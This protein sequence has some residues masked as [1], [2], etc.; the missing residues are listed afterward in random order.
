[1]R[2]AGSEDSVGGGMRHGV[3]SRGRRPRLMIKS[4]VASPSQGLN[5]A[6]GFVASN[7]RRWRVDACTARRWPVARVRGAA[8]HT[9]TYLRNRHVGAVH[10]APGHLSAAAHGLRRRRCHCRGRC[11]SVD[12]NRSTGGRGG[13]QQR[14]HHQLRRRAHG[15]CAAEPD[16]GWRWCVKKPKRQKGGLCSLLHFEAFPIIKMLA[17]QDT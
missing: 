17:I 1:M 3:D 12:N 16:V 2:L 11:A 5:W 10:H 15:V 7:A 6:R 8:L 13:Q 9:I 14:H 4:R